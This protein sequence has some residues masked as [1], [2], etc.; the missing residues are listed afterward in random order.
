MKMI[1]ID[2]LGK[3]QKKKNKQKLGLIELMARWFRFY[4][5]EMRPHY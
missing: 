1:V 2:V 3:I 5:V 4:N